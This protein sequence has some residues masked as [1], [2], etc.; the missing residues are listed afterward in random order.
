MMV[1]APTVGR[2]F[3]HKAGARG[4]SVGLSSGLASPTSPSDLAK[5]FTLTAPEIPR[6]VRRHG[7]YY[8]AS[9]PANVLP[10]GEATLCNSF[11]ASEDQ[12]R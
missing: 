12:S 7:N 5:P 3:S 6:Y 8:R 4:W 1:A 11:S 10:F 9:L 2:Y